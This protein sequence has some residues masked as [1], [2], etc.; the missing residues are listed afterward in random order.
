MPSPETISVRLIFPALFNRR[1]EEL[2]RKVAALTSSPFVLGPIPPHISLL[3]FPY[4]G[5]P[6][7]I[8]QLQSVVSTLSVCSLSADEKQCWIG[9]RVRKSRKLVALRQE[10]LEAYGSPE[11]LRK[12]F[13]PHVTL[14]LIAKSAYKTVARELQDEEL[15]HLVDIP[16]LTDV[17]IYSAEKGYR[18]ILQGRS[19]SGS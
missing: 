4:N 7:P 14:G 1:F 8:G 16:C 6:A 12:E 17:V 9:I 15:F 5:Q 3:T 18:S 10:M 19:V 11:L 2:S 13:L